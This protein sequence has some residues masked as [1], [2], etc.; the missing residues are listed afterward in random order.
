MTRQ[1]LEGGTK[2]NIFIEIGLSVDNELLICGMIDV[3]NDYRKVPISAEIIKRQTFYTYY[4]S[5]EF[6]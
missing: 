6:G 2:F 3:A 4:S 5:L 1:S